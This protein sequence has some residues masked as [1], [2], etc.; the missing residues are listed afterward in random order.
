MAHTAHGTRVEHS[1]RE[2]L[3]TL[4]NLIDLQAETTTETHITVDAITHVCIQ[5]YGRHALGCTGGS[6][7]VWP[8]GF[9]WAVAQGRTLTARAIHVLYGTVQVQYTLQYAYTRIYHTHC[10]TRTGS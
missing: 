9:V 6:K 8:V 2:N 10:T 5:A 7:A 3:S 4:D 1:H